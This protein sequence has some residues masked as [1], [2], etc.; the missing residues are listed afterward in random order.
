VKTREKARRP[1]TILLLALAGAGL[2]ACGSAPEALDRFGGDIEVEPI[3]AEGPRAA[4]RAARDPAPAPSARREGA[5]IETTS[6]RAGGERVYFNMTADA[7]VGPSRAPVTEA[8]RAGRPEDRQTLLREIPD[9]QLIAELAS[10]TAGEWTLL[11]GG[12]GGAAGGEAADPRAGEVARRLVLLGLLRPGGAA[13]E[14]EPLGEALTFA[15]N[16]ER[17][18]EERLIA[19]AYLE[20]AG[21][22]AE[23]RAIIADLWPGAAAPAPSAAEAPAV[24]PFALQSLAFATS[25]EGPGKFT[26]APASA[27]APG[28]LVLIYG[29]FRG[30]RSVVEEEGPG[31]PSYARAFAATL[32]LLSDDE[33]EID[34]LDF[35]PEARGRQRAREAAE[36]V[37]FW[38]RYRIPAQLEPGKYRIVIEARDVLGSASAT[39][40]LELEI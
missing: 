3:P 28:S 20:G 22:T 21:R 27:I 35:L 12:I 2:T 19:A 11:S 32:R 24:D 18:G 15:M 8:A 16:A 37:N 6:A 39:G 23:A 14:A 4:P 13:G 17:S 38:A 7:A 10:R 5:A 31:G 40:E 34:R 1:G 30:Y 36:A 33:R 29:E 25:I 26:P 9:D